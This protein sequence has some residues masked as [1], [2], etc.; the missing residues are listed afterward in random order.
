M[1]LHDIGKPST[2]TIARDGTLHFYKHERRGGQLAESICRR[3]KCSNRITNTIQ[4]LV[5]HHGRPR[6]LYRALREQSATPRAVTRFFIACGPHLPELLVMAAADALGKKRNHNR[7]TTEY[8]NF[9]SRL[10]QDYKKDFKTR[11]TAP[12]LIT[13][14][15]LIADFGLE[16]S[17]QFKIIL[18]RVEEERLS[19]SKMTRQEAVELVR[20][21]IKEKDR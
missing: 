7:P 18:D 13:G 1:L 17:E 9:L 15:D 16:P 3:L 4:F 12:P 8:L 14:H 21:I 10:M 20:K 11:A 5:S 19:K 2:R 6:Q